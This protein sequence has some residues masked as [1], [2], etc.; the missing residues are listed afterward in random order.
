[1]PPS[2]TRDATRNPARNRGTARLYHKDEIRLPTL[3]H[4]RATRLLIAG[5][6]LLCS[7][8]VTAGASAQSEPAVQTLP[9]Y[10]LSWSAGV[11][12][13]LTRND[14]FDQDRLA[15]AY[16]DVLAGYVFRSTS[17]FAHGAGLGF[18]I[19]L[20]EDG[21][22]TEPVGALQQF[23]LMPSYLL[24][25]TLAPDLFALGHAGIPMS[26]NAGTSVGFELG[27]ALGYRVLS[28]FG[29]YAET[30]A[31]L[32]GGASSTMHL[33]LSLELGVFVDYEVLQ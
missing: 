2:H 31:D 12:L 20:D 11:P 22:F 28:G 6:L 1:M 30:G 18:S 3:S 32:F 27:A 17:H 24:H 21:G 26:F 7:L 8:H 5:V 14:R 16:V 29:L 25:W 15:P 19:N 13:R 4:A 9:H 33:T 10:V 23:A